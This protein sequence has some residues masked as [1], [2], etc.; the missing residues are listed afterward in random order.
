MPRTRNPDQGPIG[1]LLAYGLRTQKADESLLD[2]LINVGKLGGPLI[3]SALP[4]WQDELIARF[5]TLEAVLLRLGVSYSAQMPAMHLCRKSSG[6]RFSEFLAA[7]RSESLSGNEQ[8]FLRWQGSKPKPDELLVSH[9]LP[10]AKSWTVRVVD[11]SVETKD[12]LHRAYRVEQRD[13]RRDASPFVTRL[14]VPE[15]TERRWEHEP[16]RVKLEIE[17][18]HI[19][20]FWDYFWGIGLANVPHVGVLEP[21]GA[22]AQ[23]ANLPRIVWCRIPK[24][25]SVKYPESEWKLPAW[26]RRQTTFKPGAFVVVGANTAAIEQRLG[27]DQHSFYTK[28]SDLEGKSACAR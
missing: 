6:I 25:D 2:G 22:F 12:H 1:T 17:T 4:Q 28:I 8:T 11:D 16:S 18:R 27:L 15:G 26:S 24:R 20:G 21:A 13:P 3:K 14:F 5:P 23:E 10:P 19:G 9:R 7:L